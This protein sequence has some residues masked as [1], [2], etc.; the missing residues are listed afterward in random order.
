MGFILFCL[1]PQLT[2]SDEWDVET[3]DGYHFKF[4]G[5]YLANG[6]NFL[7]KDEKLK[8]VKRLYLLSD[9][10]KKPISISFNWLNEEQKKKVKK[11]DNL[12][13]GSTEVKKK[14]KTLYELSESATKVEIEINKLI[15][16]Y[17]EQIL[18]PNFKKHNEEQLKV[19]Y[20]VAYKIKDG[21]EKFRYLSIEEDLRSYVFDYAR[22]GKYGYPEFGL[23][24]PVS[25]KRKIET[26]VNSIWGNQY[27]RLQ[28]QEIISYRDLFNRISVTYK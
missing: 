25:Q 14:V 10:D 9:K 13:Y 6:K 23:Q 21:Q 4:S 12:K 8:D 28:G 2:F 24:F 17:H 1:I 3:E 16:A 20:E 22:H 19:F 11:L 27:I 18:P 15:H 26:I 5:Q 7:E